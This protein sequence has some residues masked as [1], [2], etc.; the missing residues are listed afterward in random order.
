MLRGRAGAHALVPP[1]DPVGLTPLIELG[2]AVPL[3]RHALRSRTNA[4][5]NRAQLRWAQSP[6]WHPPPTNQISRIRR[7]E[8]RRMDFRT[9][10]LAINSFMT[11]QVH[12]KTLGVYYP[13]SGVDI[14]SAITYF[15]DAPKYTLTSELPAGAPCSDC[16]LKACQW[17]ETHWIRHHYAWS[18][19]ARMKLAFSKYGVMPI[20]QHML[21]KFLNHSSVVESFSNISFLLRIPATN[22]VVEYIQSRSIRGLD[23]PHILFLKAAPYWYIRT[24]PAFAQNS[25]YILQDE[26][27]VFPTNI[28]G[29]CNLQYFGSW[30]DLMHS[31]KCGSIRNFFSAE[32]KNFYNQTFGPSNPPLRMHFG[33]SDT[34]G[35]ENFKGVMLTARCER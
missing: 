17:Y 3:V 24:Q 10:Q 21:Q 23:T 34:C 31:Y 2:D 11:T 16:A 22:Q 15:P 32:E 1:A 33:Y 14:V 25:D 18:E 9:W 19:T 5:A 6:A 20:I 28:K 27:G 4:S 35:G 29:N 13:F 12:D 7:K 26:T 8:S 30:Q